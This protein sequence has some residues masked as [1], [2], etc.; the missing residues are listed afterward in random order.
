MFNGTMLMI[1]HKSKDGLLLEAQLPQLVLL[2][3]G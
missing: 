3:D 2:E 1:L